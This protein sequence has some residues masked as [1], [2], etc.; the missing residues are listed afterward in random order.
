M[1]IQR[2]AKGTKRS[3][4]LAEQP[5]K[6][7]RVTRGT[8][9][10][11][12]PLELA[13]T[14]QSSSI[15]PAPKLPQRQ[16]PCKA[17]ADAA[18]QATE[19]H[20]F[21]SQLLLNAVPN[22]AIVPPIEGSNTATVASTANDNREV[23]S[24]FDERFLDNFDGIDWSRLSRF[25]KPLRSQKRQKAGYTTMDI[26]LRCAVILMRSTLS[27]SSAISVAH[28]MVSLRLRSQLHP[29]LLT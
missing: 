13:D 4:G 17:L 3:A 8:G 21:E 22:E 15:I 10:N 28:T 29:R 12:Q 11:T 2:A 20:P 14:Q 5:A 24:S 19:Q 9:T 25:C 26:E 23:D 1:P 16:S 27:T 6:R 18:S 7:V